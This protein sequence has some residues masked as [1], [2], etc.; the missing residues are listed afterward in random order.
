VKTSDIPSRAPSDWRAEADPATLAVVGKLGEEAA[1]LASRCCR[2]VIQGV[3]GVD[4][5][6]GRPN[7]LHLQ[8]EIADVFALIELTIEYLGLDRAEIAF[9]EKAKR[10]YKTPWIKALADGAPTP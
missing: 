9:R 8:D 7:H 1:E 3:G 4:P 2:A 6:D 5:D 10:R